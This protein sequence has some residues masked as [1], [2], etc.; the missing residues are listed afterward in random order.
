MRCPACSTENEPGRKFCA[1]CG[2]ALARTCPSCGT[3]NAPTAKFC[4]ECGAALT[5]GARAAPV[6]TP[7][8]AAER[9]LVTVLFADLV[10]FTTASE[11]RD[12]E[13]T[14]E[15]LSRYFETARTLIERYGGTVEKFIGDAVMAVW[16][17]PVAQEDDAERAVRAALDLVAGVPDLDDA[18]QARAGVL[19]GEAAVT[20]GAEG[21]GMV[22]GD[23]VNT[24]SRVQ[25]AAEPGTVL[26]GEATKRASEA[27]IAYES[28]GDHPLKGKA[29]PTRLYRALR[30]T[31][32]RGGALKSTGLEPPF[33]GRDRELR[34]IKELFQASWDEQTAHLVSVVGV[35]GMGKSRIVWEFEK[36]IDGVAHLVWWH[37]GRCLAYGE[38]V[39]YWA[40]AEMIR[41]RAGISEGEAPDSARAK[42]RA[43][44]DQHVADEDER[45]WVEPRLAQLLGLEERQFHERED[46]F[47]GWRLLFERM[48]ESHPVVLVFEDIHWADRSLLEFVE[49]LL[50][51]SRNHAIFV[52]TLAR[53][54][55]AERH[56]EWGTMRRSFTA[57]TLAP[58]PARVMEKMLAGLVPGLPD[59]LRG[60][61]LDRA[62]GVP[63]YAV[64][65]VRMLLDRGLLE[66][67][68]DRY[69]V[70]GAIEALDVPETLHALIA[71]R[72]DGLEPAERRL[73]QNASVVGR[74]FS[75]PALA[76]VS[77]TAEGD[78]EPLLG[79]LRRKEILLLQADPRSPE[80]GQ[81]AF[82]QDLLRHVA[83]E[84]LARKE[85]KARHLGVARHLE[86]SAGRGEPDVVEV[87]A[88]HYLAAYEAAPGDDD[89]TATKAKACEAL[90][91]AGERAASLAAG[92]EAYRYYEQAAELTDDPGAEAELRERAG[93]TAH[94]AA[95]PDEARAQYERA[96]ELFEQQGAT[97][98][99]ARVS[100]R[101]GEVDW[102]LGRL[103]RAVERMER[104]FAVL[105]GDEPDE[106]FATLAAQ[107]GRLQVF[108]GNVDRSFEV[109][110]VALTL[111][112][113]MALPELVAQAM[114]TYGVLAAWQGRS[115][116]ARALFAHALQLSLEN[117]LPTPIPALRSYN[118]LGDG[119]SIRDRFEE[120]LDH[121][122]R[123][124]AL[125][126]RVGNRV[127]E[128]Q[129]L[130]ESTY[131]LMLTGH[132]DEAMTRGAEIPEERLA[133][134]N[135]PTPW[136]A[137]IAALRGDPAEARRL[138]EL[139]DPRTAGA[140][141]ADVQL[142]IGFLT[143]DAGVL[144]AEGK[145][146]ESF[147]AAEKAFEARATLS[148]LHQTIKEAFALAG[149]AA[150]KLGRLD[151]V[152]ELLSDVAGFRRG[153]LTPFVQAHASRFRAR[154]AVARGSNEDVESRF[155]TAESTFREYGIPFWLAVTQLE[156]AEWLAGQGRADDARPLL[157][158]ARE[159]FLRLEARPWLERLEG[160][161]LEAVAS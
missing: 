87:V 83:Y 34:L 142:A 64:E 149:D 98:P 50:D 148:P 48:A 16:G 124:I 160:A 155:K 114:N 97:H 81:H 4:G 120:A 71:A 60:R 30:V 46:L 25:S 19:T 41:S 59:D 23:L 51:W 53:P 12:A 121:L 91:R 74:T 150:F 86:E 11:G 143:V 105:S 55:L 99:A 158:E 22:A 131:S 42:L 123:G 39:T 89:A 28:A 146:A 129:L 56:P 153:E 126:R 2:I 110:E 73:L 35:G 76:A 122:D 152:E 139:V 44:V 113:T 27:A 94:M 9:R 100:A 75:T 140:G 62:E 136:W 54:E 130:L 47:A 10:G 66:R 93:E 141:D 37:R 154:L 6:S 8:P 119:L 103:D 88:S 106:D 26:V 77:G 127:W 5:T 63:L 49:Y 70:S 52:L 21:Q 107:L 7:A 65:T 15:L 115:E 68:G 72:L 118:N 13:E 151:K 84:T 20:L 90:A 95:R 80:R 43:A 3:A 147:T 79:G 112:E 125:A 133:S 82:V 40:L 156:H 45:A 78:L 111:A 144:A 157:E 161:G 101:L 108:A 69:R 1:E 24:A 132:W 61:I 32:T 17:T 135:T 96:I 134:L 92:E 116:T 117:D 145:D 57:I 14:R 159:V 109:L 29:E 18:L 102:Q 128:W 104:A 138:L 85:R 36:Y 58:L 137:E 33:V 38:G 31:A 67:E